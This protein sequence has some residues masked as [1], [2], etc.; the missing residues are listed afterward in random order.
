[1]SAARALFRKGSSVRVKAGIVCPDRESMSI[2]DWQ[3]RVIDTSETEGA[4]PTVGIVW[5]SVTLRAMPF[6]Y[7]EDCERQGLGWAEM[8]LSPDEVEPAAARDSEAEAGR[9]RKGMEGRFHWLG[10]DE[11]GKRIFGVIGAVD[12][13]DEWEMLKAWES[14]LKKTLS[15]PFDAKVSEYQERGPLRE[16]DRVQVRTISNVLDDLAGVLVEVRLGS[17][18]HVFPLCDLTVVGKKSKNHLPVN[19]YC[20]W[21]ANR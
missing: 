15:F 4:E 6:E 14:H 13:D 12:P 9:V 8:Y 1:M 7:V 11:E 18:E 10:L 20:V 2:A 17:Q 16:G 21:F 3:G 5:D 19:D